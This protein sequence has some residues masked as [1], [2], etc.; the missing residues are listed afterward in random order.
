MK[1]WLGAMMVALATTAGASAQA[2]PKADRDPGAHVE[3]EARRT[4]LL[5]ERVGLDEKTAKAVE[6]VLRRSMNERRQVHERMREARRKLRD[7]IE[8]DGDDQKAYQSAIAALRK[9]QND[10][11]ALKNRELDALAKHLTPKQ[12]A[13]LADTVRRAKGRTRGQGPDARDGRRRHGAR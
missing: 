5:R 7:L 9:A 2:E 3:H 8:N 12:Q 11:H 1:S 6:A 4:R 13:I 10:L